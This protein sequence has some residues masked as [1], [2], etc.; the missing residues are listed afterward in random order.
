MSSAKHDEIVYSYPYWR[1]GKLRLIKTAKE[2]FFSKSAIIFSP[3]T[4]EE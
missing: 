4:E 2:E 1:L 3:Q